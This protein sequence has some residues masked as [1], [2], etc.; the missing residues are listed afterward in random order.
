NSSAML[1]NFLFDWQKK[2][3][4]TMFAWLAQQDLE[5]I[6][7]RL[8]QQTLHQY[9][10]ENPE[11]LLE[12]IGVLFENDPAMR[13]PA[14][15]AWWSWLSSDA[16]PAG[17]MRWLQENEEFAVGFGG[18]EIAD[19]A[20]DRE[21]WT[22]ER[23]AVVLDAFALL[24]ET[25]RKTTFAQDFLERLSRYHPKTVLPYAMEQLPL[26]SQSN[27]TI[28][29]AVSNWARMGGTEPR[30]AIDWTLEN[31]EDAN[32]RWDALRFASSNWAETDTVSAAEFA[33][34]LPEK[35][36]NATFD[37]ISSQWAETD[38]DG[39]MTFLREAED[40]ALV[41][42]LTKDGF[43]W[44][45]EDRNGAAYFD[46]ALEMPPG[47]LRHDAVR[48]LFGGWA[49]SDAG[50]AADAI[51]DVPEGSLR[52]TAIQ[53]FNGFNARRDPALSVELATQ[54]TAPKVRDRELTY[55]A[56]EWIRRDPEVAKAAIRSNPKIPVP[57]KEEIFK[58][59]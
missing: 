30:A 51:Q 34:T 27:M 23:V 39:M 26:G 24:P 7:G 59:R 57:V 28:S 47:K 9:A 44:L 19:W 15:H 21:H 10:R 18:W 16:D 17:A 41:S 38:P 31:L 3:S 25:D 5:A 11:D 36:R 50:K 2:D 14:G 40:P 42:E 13:M 1:P 32:A 54:I 12:K 22:A 8:L 46:A 56:R 53:G 33:L 37:G 48:G 20:T 58:K 43:R 4:D 52:N 55:R 45:A 29:R 6:D 49:L 35:D